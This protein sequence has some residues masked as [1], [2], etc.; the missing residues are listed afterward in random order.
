MANDDIR[1]KILARR[2]RFVVAAVAG[3]SSGA[4]GCC[5]REGISEP[6]LS[7]EQPRPDASH[8]APHVC[9]EFVPDEDEEPK[10]CLAP[11]APSSKPPG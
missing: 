2:T 5:D 1:N 11:P 4:A 9:L 10:V 7:I 3:L 6:C 8:T